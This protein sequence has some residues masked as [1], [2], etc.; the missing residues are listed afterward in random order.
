[1]LPH[2]PEI[3]FTPLFETPWQIV[4]PAPHRWISE[5]RIPANE[6]AKEP[7]LLPERSSPARALIDRHFAREKIVLNCVAE[8]EYLE[9]VKELL[10]AGMGIG[11]L[12]SWIVEEEVRLSNNF[13]VYVSWDDWASVPE[14]E[15]SE[16]ILEAYKQA[17]G[18]PEMLRI[19]VAMGLT[20]LEAKQLG[21]DLDA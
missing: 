7:C 4:V 21:V 9:T 13:R 2:D 6:L 19:S 8:V 3:D 5:H 15:R 1:M 18:V 10:R 11:I 17:K 16:I 14:T 12:P 20:P